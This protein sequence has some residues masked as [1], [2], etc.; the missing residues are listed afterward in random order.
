[1]RLFVTGGAGHTGCNFLNLYL[2]DKKD[3]EAIVLVRSQSNKDYLPD[4]FGDNLKLVEG[5][6][7]EKEISALMQGCDAV[8]HIAHQTLCPQVGDAALRAGVNR[9]FFVTTTGVFSKFNDLSAG[10]RDIEEGIRNSGLNWTILRPTMIF[11]SE[12]DANLHKLL[13]YVDKHSVYPVFGNGRCLMQPVF[14]GDLAAGLLSALNF[15]DKTS[16][17]EYNLPGSTPLTYNEI[18]ETSIKE[19][20]R[21]AALVHIPHTLCLCM[22]TI[23]E[24]ILRSR[25]PI[26]SEQVRRLTEDK[27]Y[28]WDSARVDFEYKPGSFAERIGLEVKRLRSVGLLSK[29]A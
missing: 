7:R 27:A 25:S 8:M 13:R 6:L 17:K 2:S 19:L 3:N 9:V 28:S 29:R 16:L 5:D 21:K 18:I 23:A 24:L 1:M 14:V 15:E 11:G 20:G 4:G 22:S 12:R 10:Y 26:K